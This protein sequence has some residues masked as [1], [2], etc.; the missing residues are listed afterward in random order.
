MEAPTTAPQF[1]ISLSYLDLSTLTVVEVE[2]SDAE[3]ADAMLEAAYDDFT[4]GSAPTVPTCPACHRAQRADW[5]RHICT[6]AGCRLGAFH[7][8]PCRNCRQPRFAC[9]C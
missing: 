5:G 1:D 7:A 2:P 4:A 9:F 8:A 3:I 6:N